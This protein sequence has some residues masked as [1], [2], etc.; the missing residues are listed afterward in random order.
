MGILKYYGYVTV[1]ILLPTLLLTAA[2]L[3]MNHPAP[4]EE[5]QVELGMYI[6]QCMVTV[7]GAGLFALLFS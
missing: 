4:V 6:L 5:L 3:Q 2:T 1:S 7:C